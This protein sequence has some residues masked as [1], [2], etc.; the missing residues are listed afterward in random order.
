MNQEEPQYISLINLIIEKGTLEKGRNGNTYCIFGYSMRFD[1]GNNKIPILTTKKLSWVTCIKELLWFIKGETDNKILQSQGVHIWDGNASKEFLES[2]NLNYEE[3]LLGPIY[4]FQWRHFQGDYEKQTGG[5]DQLQ[6]IIDQLKNPETR[7]SR[8]L[9]MSAW[10][11]CQIDDMVLP[12]CHVM[13]HF[14]YCNN[15]LSCAMYQRSGDVGLGVPFN[16]LSYS[17]LTHLIAKH[18]NLD[19]G[20]FVYFLG[21]AHIYEEHINSLKEQII[22]EPYIFPKINI[23]NIYENIDD[24]T[25]DDFEIIDYQCHKK[26]VMNMIV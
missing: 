22:R 12:P 10:N 19:V 5:I 24:Y 21:N 20:E 23:K 9:I 17:V 14:Q 8:R 1:L 2:R 4:G 16:I 25:I 13:C 3:G 11:P 15:K 7:N 18:C 26:I 6:Y